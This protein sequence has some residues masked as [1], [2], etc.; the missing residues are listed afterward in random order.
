MIATIREHGGH[1]TERHIIARELAWNQVPKDDAVKL[2]KEIVPD[3]NEEI[4]RYQVDYAYEKIL[5]EGE[6]RYGPK[7]PAVRPYLEELTIDTREIEGQTP[8]KLIRDVRGEIRKNIENPFGSGYIHRIDVPPG[9]GKTRTA[10][11]TLLEKAIKT[12]EGFTVFGNRHEFLEE[13]VEYVKNNYPELA[14]RV[15]QVKGATRLCPTLSEENKWRGLYNKGFTPRG[16]HA[17]EDFPCD[18]DC[19]YMKQFEEINESSIVFAPPEFQHVE[20]V[21]KDKIVI[22]DD[23]RP[24]RLERKT[25]G[26][27]EDE[28]KKA[29]TIFDNIDDVREYAERRDRYI[30]KFYGSY[31]LC[32]VVG[33]DEPDKVIEEIST[34]EW[35]KRAYAENLHFYALDAYLAWRSPF[36]LYESAGGLKE[37]I[38]ITAA[39]DKRYKLRIISPKDTSKHKK[40][41]ILNAGTSNEMYEPYFQEQIKTV[42]KATDREIWTPGTNYIQI[43][44]RKNP[45][46][47]DNPTLLRKERK[48]YEVDMT[49]L[50]TQLEDITDEHD[51]VL[52]VSSKKF[53]GKARN[54]EYKKLAEQLDRATAVRHYSD[55]DGINKYENFDAVI[56]VG[57]P[58]PGDNVI[59]ETA[60]LHGVKYK[61]PDHRESEPDYGEAQY[62]YDFYTKQQ[63]YQA[64]H[65]VRPLTSK[66]TDVYLLTTVY[67]TEDLPPVIYNEALPSGSYITILTRNV[68]R[69]MDEHH[70]VTAGKL[71]QLLGVG[72]NYLKQALMK[73]GARF[74]IDDGPGGYK[75]KTEARII[76]YKRRIWSEDI[77]STYSAAVESPANQLTLPETACPGPD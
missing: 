15:I 41:F 52:V 57:Y 49:A 69:N 10:I 40:T 63:V 73:L 7:H 31:R 33:G 16:L 13:Q 4:T 32:Q 51:Q 44:K 48:R 18:N 30:E 6:N 1:H 54:G 5:V 23:V 77:E 8:D 38:K 20:S 11:N 75:L 26:I 58:H 76:N 39:G 24:D 47:N 50:V 74:G 19:V 64:M 35:G 45:V 21:T 72:E 12:G 3:F 61:E 42:C 34:F 37:K 53:L 59:R 28:M 56:L 14:D 36:N 25:S 60:E 68:L 17:L 43:G 22:Y 29:I 62:I 71:S 67:P 55:I 70:P 9:V 46:A 2:F 27:T 65:R 66:K